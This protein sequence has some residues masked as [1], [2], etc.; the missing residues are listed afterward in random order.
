MALDAAPAEK[1]LLAMCAAD[2]RIIEW[3]LRRALSIT[4]AG[5]VK[6]KARLL[7]KGW[8]LMGHKVSDFK[9]PENE[10]KVAHDA[11][12]LIVH[13]E[14]LD[15]RYLLASEKLLCAFYVAFPD[16]T[17]VRVSDELGISPSGLKK[18]KSGLLEKKVL[19]TTTAGYTV[20]LPGYLLIRD[21]LGGHFI[22]EKE[23]EETGHKISLPTPR[24]IPAMDLFRKW[25]AYSDYQHRIN[26]SLSACLHYTD[27]MLKRIEIESPEGAERDMVLATLKN[28]ADANF[29]I[30]F[31]AENAPPITELQML[32]QIS[33]ATAEELAAF[34]VH[35]EG[36]QLAGIPPQ[37]LLGFFGA[38]QQV[39]DG[40]DDA[41]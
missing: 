30:G 15:I 2:S 39:G 4:H 6:L 26:G 25:S 8:L 36:S 10:Q 41:S 12:P 21:E 16:A 28:M 38:G 31:V 7:E 17:N 35:V 22:S 11:R 5:L 27:K 14:L 24:L 1:L 13:S 9:A 40:N 37:K 32:D 20:R 33:K 34:R 3:R 19:V 29:A 23:A 18:L